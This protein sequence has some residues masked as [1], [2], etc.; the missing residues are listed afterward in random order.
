MKNINYAIIFNIITYKTNN[1]LLR[2]L[3]GSGIM[4]FGL[5]EINFE[6]ILS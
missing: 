4:L 3:Y 2:L 6:D 5:L 1:I